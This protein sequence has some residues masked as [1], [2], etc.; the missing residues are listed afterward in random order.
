MELTL[1]GR[2]SVCTSRVRQHFNNERES[3]K[4]HSGGS[5]WVA[6]EA[7]IM[8]QTGKPGVRTPAEAEA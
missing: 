1:G 5:L 2:V 4:M 7:V 3:A 6:L 8:G